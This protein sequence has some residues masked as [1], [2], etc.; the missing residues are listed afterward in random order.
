MKM[1]TPHCAILDRHSRAGGN[2]GWFD[3]INLDSRFRGYDGTQ[4]A[5]F[6]KEITKIS[7]NLNSEL[8]ALHAFV[9]KNILTATQ[10]ATI[11]C[12]HGN[13]S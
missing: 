2:P 5:V 1:E 9:V 3:R 7:D 8:R 11:F 10:E 6:S 12:D 4:K 13:E